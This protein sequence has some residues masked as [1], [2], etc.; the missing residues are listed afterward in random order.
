MYRVI[1]LAL[2][3]CFGGLAFGQV[4]DA[5]VLEAELSR[6]RAYVGDVVSYQVVVR[7]A[8]EGTPPAVDFPAGVRAEYRGASSRKF[9][10]MRSVNGRQRT[11]TDAYFSH[12]YALTIVNEGEIVIPGAVLMQGKERYQSNQVKMSALLPAVSAQDFLEIELPNRSVYVGE[13]VVVEVSWWIGGNTQDLSFESSVF[14]E[15]MRVIATSPSGRTGEQVELT[16]DGERFVGFVEAGRYQG[17]TMRRLVFD[18]V[19]TPSRAGEEEFGPVRAVFNRLDDHGRRERRFAQAEAATMRVVGVPG[20]GKPD[21]YRGLI[22]EFSILSDA[23]NTIVNVG[24]PIQFRAL[25]RGAEPMM[26]LEETLE[27]QGLAAAGFRVSADGWREVERNRGGERLFETTIRATDASVEEIPAISLPAFNPVSGEF[28]VFESVPIPIVVNAVRTVTLSDAVVAGGIDEPSG[29]VARD[30]LVRSPS[31][32]WT[33]PDAETIAGSG[34]VFS[35]GRVLGD[36]VWVSV[37]VVI[38]VMPV[39]AFG[40][41]VARR[42]RDP[43]DV[44]IGRA[45]KRAKRLH[46][47]GDDVGAI[48]VYGG[49]VLGVEPGSLTGADLARLGVSDEIARRSAS[50]LTESEG[51]AY[52]SMSGGGSDGSLL[53]EMRRDVRRHR[54]GRKERRATR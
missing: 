2:V 43:R 21:G 10:T 30:E 29:G 5:V 19:V 51:V 18:L 45:W 35:L 48:R 15:S 7:G 50:V 42:S 4:D 39:V 3:M 16:L 14:P 6:G 11:V 44:E 1:L 46:D 9:T 8:N 22:G 25:V 54:A 27:M 41:G 28:E 23:S 33:H 49:A 36:P 13:S 38:V 17:Q 26:G 31:V 47:R 20:G 34:R 24:D 32:L 53:R 37:L 40:V 52:G 12:Q